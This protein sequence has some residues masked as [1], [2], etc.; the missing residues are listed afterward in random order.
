M[1][2]HGLIH[3]SINQSLY[4]SFQQHM[5]HTHTCVVPSLRCSRLCMPCTESSL[6]ILSF[7]ERVVHL[8]SIMSVFKC[9]HILHRFNFH[10]CQCIIHVYCRSFVRSFVLSPLPVHSQYMHSSSCMFRWTPTTTIHFL[11]LSL[12]LTH[13][14][15]SLS[16]S[17]P[18]YMH[19]YHS[20]TLPQLLKSPWLAHTTKPTTA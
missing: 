9:M 4:E 15:V 17:P 6:L 14:H 2:T 19:V 10:L 20:T 5:A 7:M 16:L 3:L 12:H 18:L 8:L 11:S 1:P 13:V